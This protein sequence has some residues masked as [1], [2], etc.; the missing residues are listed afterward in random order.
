MTPIRQLQE[1]GQLF[2][3]IL[4]DHRSTSPE[5]ASHAPAPTG[6]E[7][8]FA[9]QVFSSRLPQIIR[10][11]RRRAFA[12]ALGGQ[13][14]ATHAQVE[15]LLAAM[16]LIPAGDASNVPHYD[17]EESLAIAN[18][19]LET[20]PGEMGP[21]TA[22]LRFVKGL[23]PAWLTVPLYKELLAPFSDI[24]QTVL[25]ATTDELLDLARSWSDTEPSAGELS[26]HIPE[27]LKA[28][29]CISVEDLREPSHLNSRIFVHVEDDFSYVLWYKAPEN[30]YRALVR[31]LGGKSATMRTKRGRALEDFVARRI[32]K[33]APAWEMRRGTYIDGREKDIL[34]WDEDLGLAIECKSL[35]LRDAATGWSNLHLESDVNTVQEALGQVQPALN[36][37]QK[38]GKSDDGLEIPRRPGAMGIVVTDEPFSSYIRAG[39]DRLEM[40]DD[41]VHWHGRTVWVTNFIDFHHL[42]SVSESISVLLHY[43]TKYRNRAE[44][45]KMDEPES[46][47]TYSVPSTHLMAKAGVLMVVPEHDWERAR[48]HDGN[49]WRPNW[50][51]RREE[52]QKWDRLGQSRKAMRIVQQDLDAAVRVEWDKIRSLED[53]SDPV[54]PNLARQIM[55][56]IEQRRAAAPKHP[57]DYL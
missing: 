24:S 10:R 19:I 26:V 11:Y 43:L 55:R 12:I 54:D 7:A 50:F 46:W 39:I 25:G 29:I 38:G 51:R 22:A 36:L 16:S 27:E 4:H 31:V 42:L 23:R 34:A 3:V 33:F 28:Q 49:G 57:Y 30:M 14:Q 45:R 6:R 40:S 44:I 13:G 32:G 18:Q 48:H 41:E 2:G 47:S 21:T 20:A 35:A 8:W 1:G 17:V 5:A 53:P 9:S 15:L 56:D 52:V 37:L